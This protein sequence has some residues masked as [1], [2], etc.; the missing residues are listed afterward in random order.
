MIMA[1]ILVIVAFAYVIAAA[2][3]AGPEVAMAIHHY[4]AVG[5]CRLLSAAP[6]V[7]T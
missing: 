3:E 6:E 1:K 2:L 5:S 7:R 4:Q